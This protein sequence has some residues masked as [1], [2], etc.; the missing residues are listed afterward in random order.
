MGRYLEAVDDDEPCMW[1]KIDN[2][3]VTTLLFVS[4]LHLLGMYIF[5]T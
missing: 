1:T 5:L 3:P 2:S 4:P